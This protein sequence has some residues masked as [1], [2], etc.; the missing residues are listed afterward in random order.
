MS[1][2]K[3]RVVALVLMSV[4]VFGCGKKDPPPNPPAAAESNSTMNTSSVAPG[5][6]P[7]NAPPEIREKIMQ[8]QG[9]K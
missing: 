2:S 3:I 6:V 7:A 4:G 8:G 5:Q 9:K 1:T